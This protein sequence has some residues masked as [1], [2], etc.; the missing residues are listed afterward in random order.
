MVLFIVGL[1]SMTLFQEKLA[2]LPW[3]SRWVDGLPRDPHL[4][5]LRVLETSPIIVRFVI[6][7]YYSGAL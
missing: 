6:Y 5:A 4:A 2:G 1:V 7:Y 3:F